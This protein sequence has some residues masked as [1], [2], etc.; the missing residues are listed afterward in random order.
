MAEENISLEERLHLIEAAVAFTSYVTDKYPQIN[1]DN[2]LNYSISGSLAVILLSQADTIEK[3]DSSHLPE[4]SLKEEQRLSDGLRD[5]LAGFI[6]KIGDFDFVTTE[7]YDEALREANKY[8]PKEPEK[9]RSLRSRIITKGGG[10]PSVDELPDLAKNILAE[11]KPGTKIMCDPVETYGHDHVVRVR[12][13]GKD[14]FISDPMQ[15][16]GYKVLHLMQSFSNKPS[17]F[18]RDF[19]ILHGAL[20]ELYSEDELIESAYSVIVRFEDSMSRYGPKAVGYTA[21][22]DRNPDFDS[23]IR[24]FFEKLKGYDKNHRRIMQSKS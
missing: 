12:V 9:Y 8:W 24:P 4:V 20:S 21:E 11:A 14:Y 18:T 6:R 13:R 2:K 17:R 22:L 16:F 7:A 1:D 15:I 10:G 3:L 23:T 19:A 5:K